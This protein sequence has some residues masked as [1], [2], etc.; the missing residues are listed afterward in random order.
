[1]GGYP[2]LK[3]VKYAL[4]LR[5]L[6]VLRGENGSGEKSFL[7][8][9]VQ[10][11]HA[12]FSARRAWT[13]HQQKVIFV[14]KIVAGKMRSLAKIAHTLLLCLRWKRGFGFMGNNFPWHTEK[15]G[16]ADAL[17]GRL[18]FALNGGAR[19]TRLLAFAP[20]KQNLHEKMAP[21]NYLNNLVDKRENTVCLP[22]IM[23]WFRADSGGNRGFRKQLRKH[24]TIQVAASAC[25]RFK[26][27]LDVVT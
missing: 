12:I 2:G 10:S 7:D 26:K 1:M 23:R 22:A 13:L 25:I 18:L 24:L 14:K 19:S 16:Q 8:Q 11:L 15:Y 5:C 21:T 3:R 20:D 9:P 17:D 6:Y 4:Y 27:K